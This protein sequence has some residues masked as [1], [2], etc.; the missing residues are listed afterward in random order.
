MTRTEF[1]ENITSWGDLIGYCD[2]MG[3]DFMS[4]VYSEG[5]MDDFVDEKICDLIKHVNWREVR[6]YLDDLSDGYDY[7]I[8]T[9]DDGFEGADDYDFDRY[10]LDILEYGD[11]QGVWEA[12]EE[13]ET[14]EDIEEEDIEEEGAPP[15]ARTEEDTDDVTLDEWISLGE[16]FANC[17]TTVQ[18]IVDDA[19]REK[20]QQEK[21]WTEFYQ[22]EG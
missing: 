15:T 14:E 5:S 12:D 9:E 11:E 17:R 20:E 22:M 4:N 8:L 19:E 18:V 2:N 7:Y 3:W 1:K 21:A 6:E 13:D 16:L 10:K